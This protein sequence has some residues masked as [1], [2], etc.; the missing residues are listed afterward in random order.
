M[1]VDRCNRTLLFDLV[2][3]VNY[4]PLRFAFEFLWFQTSATTAAKQTTDDTL[5]NLPESKQCYGG[6]YIITTMI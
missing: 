6:K 3:F 4:Y 1:M 5:I 2:K